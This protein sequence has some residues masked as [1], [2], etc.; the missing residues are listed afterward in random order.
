MFTTLNHRE[1]MYVEKRENAVA[2]AVCMHYIMSLDP[3]STALQDQKVEG[4]LSQDRRT[5]PI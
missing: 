3:T 2:V 4:E 5:F 1:A